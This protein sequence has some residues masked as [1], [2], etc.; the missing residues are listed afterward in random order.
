MFARVKLLNGFSKELTYT[1]PTAL[2]QNI[3]RGSIVKVPLQNRVEQ[4]CV[5]AIEKMA[6]GS[7]AIRDIISCEQF[8]PDT[9]YHDF[10]QIIAQYY[11]LEPITLYQRLR[12]CLFSS[13]RDTLL[14]KEKISQHSV[15]LTAEQESIV[16]DFLPH[17]EKTEFFPSLLHGVT[18][19]GK[20]EVYKKLLAHTIALKKTALFLAPEI[21]LAH[22]FA[23]LFRAS[24]INVPVYTFHSATPRGEKRALWQALI[25]GTP[26]VI[27]GVHLPILL[28]IKNIGLIIVDEEHDAGYQEKKHPRLNSKEM[29][30]MRAHFYRIP[31]MLGSATP[32]VA[33]CAAAQKNNWLVYRLRE[34]FSGA[35]PQ[36]SVVNLTA[37][38]RKKTFWISHRLER[39]IRECLARKKQ[40]L[41]FLNRRGYSFFV[42]CHS[43]GAVP[44][45]NACSVSLTLHEND[46]LKC[47]YCGFSR[48]VSACS[49]CASHDF[50]K[51]GIGTQQ[52]VAQ[53]QTLFPEARI[54]RVD[55]D[56]AR[57]PQEWE[58]LCRAVTQEEIDIL[59]GTQ[60]ITKGHHFP[61][62]TLVGIIWADAN[63][64]FPRYNAAEVSLQQ[65]LQ[66][67]GRAGRAHTHSHVVVQT[68]SEH[69]IFSFLSEE[70]YEQFCTQEIEIRRKTGYPP[71][72]RCA[73]IEIRHAV[74]EIAEH[75][76]HR[77]AHILREQ[78]NCTVLGPVPPIIEKI[79]NIFTQQIFLKSPSAMAL[80][81]LFTKLKAHTFESKL[82]FTQSPLS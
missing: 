57:K 1:I 36:I 73:Q 53:L 29:A 8:P 3:Q 30:L 68:L 28:P 65:I 48:T 6:T 25:A 11:A 60:L 4:A 71:A 67:A 18:G 33:T 66:V 23:M 54:A 31:I 13:E 64:H 9:N 72:V 41:I 26:I 63:V 62:V 20:T 81:T 32:S 40:A 74:Q 21:M 76:A 79:H 16:T 38:A 58:S 78:E 37:N 45:C 50:A 46:I 52:L 5:V 44:Q 55:G 10:C 42:Q 43:C 47:H 61:G 19:S 7:F 77:I 22:H 51:K 59:V 82:F 39:E 56:I 17:L 70:L 27:I 34:R 14:P 2:E 35:F 15:Q 12:S 75:D 69:P 80:S 49:N 24:L